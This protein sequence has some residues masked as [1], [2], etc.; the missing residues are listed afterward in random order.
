MISLRRLILL[1]PLIL[2][3]CAILEGTPPPIPLR[4]LA[5]R[6]DCSYHDETNTRGTLKL[7]VASARVRS[8]D[9]RIDYPQH[10][11]CHFALKDFRQT[12][13]MPSIELTQINGTCR[14]LMWE[15]G[16]RVTVGF[17]QC[18]AMCTGSAHDQL[19]PMIYDRGDGSCA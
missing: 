5:A 14:V 15:Q 3:A 6:V 17:Q 7:D 13:E 1:L 10:G 16:A 2:S 8:F 12:R 4:P 19:L 11:V 9:A 18:E